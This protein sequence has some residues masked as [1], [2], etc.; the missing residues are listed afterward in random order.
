LAPDSLFRSPRNPV[1]DRIILHPQPGKKKRGPWRWYFLIS[2]CL[3]I[4]GAASTLTGVYLITRKFV[5][6]LPPLKQLENIQPNLITRIFDRKGKLL[7]EFYMENRV[8]TPLD[9]LPLHLRN[10]FIA[11]EDR[12]FFQ[13]WGLDVPRNIKAVLVDIQAGYAKQGASTITQQLTR[14]LFLTAK[15][16]IYSKN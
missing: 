10:G 4:I 6:Q 8:W 5:D 2:L 16:N 3:V 14:N 9:S 1:T 15:K 13:H 11:L 7:K 12:K